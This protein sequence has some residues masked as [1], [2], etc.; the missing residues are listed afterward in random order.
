MQRSYPGMWLYDLAPFVILQDRAMNEITHSTVAHD[1]A[2]SSKVRDK[3]DTE[4]S[5]LRNGLFFYD[6]E[7]SLRNPVCPSRS[8]QAH[9]KHL[10]LN[11]IKKRTCRKVFRRGCR[12][13]SEHDSVEIVSWPAVEP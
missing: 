8:S 12:V 9:P 3:E 11:S 13:S 2:I 6:C 4:N 5:A 7:G 10:S 1:F